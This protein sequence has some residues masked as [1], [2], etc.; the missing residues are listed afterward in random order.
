MIP[1]AFAIVILLQCTIL[2]IHFSREN[3]KIN[4]YISFSDYLVAN[5]RKKQKIVTKT[6]K[7]KLSLQKILPNDVFNHH[8][9][10]Q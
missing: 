4:N 5:I 1:I 10:L 3:K 6:Q 8:D 9:Q 2:L 7:K